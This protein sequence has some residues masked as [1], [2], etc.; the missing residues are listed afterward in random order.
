MKKKSAENVQIVQRLK[1]LQEGGRVL[2]NALTAARSRSL[3]SAGG[4]RLCSKKGRREASRQKRNST[5]ASHVVPHRSTSLARRRLTSQSGRD[6]VRSAWYGRSCVCCVVIVFYSGKEVLV[7]IFC[8]VC[9][10]MYARRVHA[11]LSTLRF[12]KPMESMQV[13][14]WSKTKNGMMMYMQQGVRRKV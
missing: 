3:F 8:N 10:C 14:L 1:K 5:R 6:V 4:P 12:K 9:M 13:C 7:Y 2:K 11:S